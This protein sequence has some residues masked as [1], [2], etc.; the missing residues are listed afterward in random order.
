MSN[1]ISSRDNDWVDF[2]NHWSS[3]QREEEYPWL[4]KLIAIEAGLVIS[5]TTVIVCYIISS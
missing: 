4:E 5:I 3:W 1:S 2:M